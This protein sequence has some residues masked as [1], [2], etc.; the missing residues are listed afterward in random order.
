MKFK[1]ATCQFPVDQDVERNCRFVLQQM[2]SAK[3]RG[4]DVVHFCETS[5]SGYA[6]VEFPSFKGFDWELLNRC[7]QRVMELARQ[8]RVWVI[9]GSSHRL[10]GR[11]KPHNSL[12]IINDRGRIIDRYDKMFC[13]GDRQ[14][15]NG[16]LQHYTSGDHFCVFSIRGIRCGT[17]ICHDFRYDELAREYKR[18]GVQILFCSYHNGHVSRAH[19]EKFKHI[20]PV[21]VPATMQTYAANNFFWISANNT[22]ARYS[23]WPSFFVRP[24]GYISGRLRNNVTGILIST[25]DTKAKLYD[26]SEHWRDRAL[27]GVYHSGTLVRDKRSTCRTEY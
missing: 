24:D 12:Y 21:I 23:Q 18:R 6:G 5:L 15:R 27:K 4:A 2:A 19:V 3:K 20:H 8:L 17:L 13:T 9:L 10:T 25:V 1:I 26:A 11:R 14:Q 22:S 16:G 7:T